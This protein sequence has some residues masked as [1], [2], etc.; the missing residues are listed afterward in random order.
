MLVGRYYHVMRAG[1]FGIVASILRHTGPQ[2]A[3]ATI[4]RLGKAARRLANRFLS[5]TETTILRGQCVFLRKL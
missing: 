5:A 4:G 3:L 1:L 2:N